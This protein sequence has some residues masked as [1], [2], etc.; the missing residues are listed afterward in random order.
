[1]GDES[2]AAGGLPAQPF[3]FNGRGSDYFGI[4]IVN[5]LLTIVTLGIYSPWAKVRRMQYL[6]R[7]TEVA[8]SSFDFHGKPLAILIGR[9]VALALLISYNYSVRLRSPLTLAI[10]VLVAVVLPWLLRNSLRFRLYNTSWRG[11][12]FSFHGSVGG[13]YAAFLGNYLLALVTLYLAAPYAH[14]RL[15]RYQHNNARFGTTPF[16]FH[17]SVGSFYKVYGIFVAALIGMGVVTLLGLSAIGAGAMLASMKMQGGQPKIDPRQFLLLAGLL[18]AALIFMS[19]VIG[20]LFQSML[21]NLIWNNTRLGEHRFQCRQSA[22][23]LMGLYI[24]NFLGV[25]FTLGLFTPWAV[26]RLARYRVECMSLL[27]ASALAE[28]VAGEAE[29][30][31]AIGE[32]TAAVFDIDISL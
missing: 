3:R 4:W 23:P 17:A 22:L 32:E 14:Q 8:G 19:L 2:L 7:N 6:Y 15:K 27:P 26:V 13:A 18:Y 28:F 29:Q 16:S 5:V 31:S 10:I 20:P 9:I 25:V 30:P 24:T 21:T 11:L 12:R 1:M